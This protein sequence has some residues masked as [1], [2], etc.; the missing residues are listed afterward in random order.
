VYALLPL[1]SRSRASVAARRRDG[2]SRPSRQ[3][4]RPRAPV[5]TSSSVHSSNGVSGKW[6]LLRSAS[7]P[8]LRGVG[9]RRG[10]SVAADLTCKER[11]PERVTSARQVTIE[12]LAALVLHLLRP[13][14]V[15]QRLPVLERHRLRHR[16]D[17]P[18]RAR[19]SLVA[20]TQ[21]P[22][23]SVLA[24]FLA[25]ASDPRPPGLPTPPPRPQNAQRFARRSEPGSRTGQSAGAGRLRSGAFANNHRG[26]DRE[27]VREAD[28]TFR[29]TFAPLET[30]ERQPR[31]NAKTADSACG[32]KWPGPRAFLAQKRGARPAGR[33][34]F[35][36]VPTVVETI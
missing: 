36:R 34:A 16:R 2:Q 1:A 6:L 8:G 3:P 11:S 22:S 31:A 21:P 15:R 10:L 20:S 12:E 26:A 7:S 24:H 30:I 19:P 13:R 35:M 29:V 28:V 23:P 18:T 32:R 33:P 4:A 9:S 5:I 27:T 17:H 14:P 25:P